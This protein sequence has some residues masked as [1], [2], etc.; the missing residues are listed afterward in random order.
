MNEGRAVNGSGDG[1]LS[2]VGRRIERFVDLLAAAGSGDATEGLAELE[3]T[4]VEVAELGPRIIAPLRQLMVTA[5]GVRQVVV[6]GLVLGGSQPE[7]GGLFSA[8]DAE[9]ARRV[10]R[11]AVAGKGEDEQYRA[12]YF[13]SQLG[14][15]AADHGA[16]ARLLG[17]P[18]K[19]TSVCAA[20]ALLRMPGKREE[21]DEAFSQAHKVLR[22]AAAHGT[23]FQR[24]VAGQGLVASGQ[25]S[26]EVATQLAAVLP[27][28]PPAQAYVIITTLA[29]MRQHAAACA[30]AL[31]KVADAKRCGDALRGHAAYAFACV[32]EEGRSARLAKRSVGKRRREEEEDEQVST[33]V[34]ERETVLR[35]L[36]S[37]CRA[38][39]LGVLHGMHERGWLPEWADE[40]VVDA[41]QEADEDFNWVGLKV[42]ASAPQQVVA[43]FVP[44]LLFK[45]GTCRSIE[46]RTAIAEG[47][48][49]AREHCV[50][51]LVQ[52]IRELD[53]DRLPVVAM[54]LAAMGQFAA[55]VLRRALDEAGDE[56]RLVVAT[57]LRDVGP[58]DAALAPLVGS[59]L[60][61]PLGEDLALTAE[62]I[63]AAWGPHAEG[64]LPQLVRRIARIGLAAV[65]SIRIVQSF[66]DLGLAEVERCRA[67]CSGEERAHLDA[68]FKPQATDAPPGE[69]ASMVARLAKLPRQMLVAFLY[70]MEEWKNGALSFK[71]TA[72]RLR[73]RRA[74]G[75][76]REYKPV[77]GRQLQEYLNEVTGASG[78]AV[79][80]RRNRATGRLTKDAE[81]VS[82]AV[83]RA[84]GHSE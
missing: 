65:I 14:A 76:I 12:A 49:R 72:D 53:L 41:L 70:M 63:L 38:V 30:D 57:L 7:T 74:R 55:E 73:A 77:S 29:G 39:R 79:L 60:D 33:V 3:Q 20:A 6:A 26:A 68:V 1:S 48:A 51:P 82:R 18:R 15:V 32:V 17:S 61:D 84:S 66:G 35:L 67:S 62:H 24:A 59:W 36:S 54:A 47:L 43:R 44:D 9:G 80:Q 40:K 45:A 81:A 78:Y 25:A 34:S 16:L 71:K 22:S 31:S 8:E 56:T 64:A 46:L 27:D 2:S 21:I 52:V 69:L 5:S 42:I 58:V 11:K 75:E 23:A 28:A 10:L 37:D 4:N 19:D 13:L 50:E 83:R